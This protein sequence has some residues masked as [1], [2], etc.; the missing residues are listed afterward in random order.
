MCWVGGGGTSYVFC[1]K[2]KKKRKQEK[3][4]LNYPKYPIISY[5]ELWSSIS[6]R[7]GSECLCAT[8]K[9]GGK[10]ALHILVNIFISDNNQKLSFYHLK[11]IPL[12]QH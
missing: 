10:M 1:K 8:E 3:L 11:I 7:V 5:L 12:V 9:H 2:N 6:F 4:S